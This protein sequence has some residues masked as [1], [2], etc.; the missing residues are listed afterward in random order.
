[1]L[2][3]LEKLLNQL[4]IHQGPVPYLLVLVLLLACGFGLPMPEDIILFSAGL[5]SYYG[6]AR[7]WPMIAVSFVGVLTGDFSVYCIGSFSG[8]NSCASTGCKKS[9]RPNACAWCGGS[10]TARAIK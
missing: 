2:R 1:M 5:L 3:P 8:A 6:K 10:C 4:M 7:V 9:F